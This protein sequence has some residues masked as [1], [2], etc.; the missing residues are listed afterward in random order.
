MDRQSRKAAADTQR[1]LQQARK[2]AESL[3]LRPE[4]S[5]NWDKL[6]ASRSPFIIDYITLIQDA[7]GWTVPMLYEKAEL[8]ASPHNYSIHCI[9]QW[10]IEKRYGS[11]TTAAVKAMAKVLQEAHSQ[12]DTPFIDP[13]CFELLYDYNQDV[14]DQKVA[15]FRME[16]RRD[17]TQKKFPDRWEAAIK[18]KPHLGKLLKC[19]RNSFGLSVEKFVIYAHYIN[20]DS[21]IT[22]AIV[23]SLE[24]ER[25]G[26]KR[27]NEYLTVV[28]SYRNAH[29]LT[30]PQDT[31]IDETVKEYTEAGKL[32][33]TAYNAKKSGTGLKALRLST[34]LILEDVAPTIGC[35][36]ANL[37]MIEN[38][39]GPINAENFS[40]LLTLYTQHAN[41]NPV[42]RRIINEENIGL[43]REW[44]TPRKKKQGTTRPPPPSGTPSK[45]IIGQ[46]D[47]VSRLGEPNRLMMF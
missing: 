21:S 44:Y 25:G 26:S 33:N 20:K 15:D 22:S 43:I 4:F 3:A 24:L 23:D 31:H 12:L 28:E 30:Y 34:D 35:T 17:A 8:A 45:T 42:S 11:P 29:R 18:N 36:G 40:T 46:I 19:M 39:K 1:A 32:W 14:W 6:E 7:M 5:Q 9:P 10:K 16:K 13:K 27:A 2:L 41:D 47:H 38:N 37:S